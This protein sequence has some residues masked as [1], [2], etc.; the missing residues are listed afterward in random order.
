MPKKPYQPKSIEEHNF[1]SY[2]SSHKGV[3]FQAEPWPHPLNHE[4]TEDETIFSYEEYARKPHTP[5]PV[6]QISTQAANKLYPRVLD[7]PIRL[8]GDNTYHLPEE[9]AD[10]APILQGI[11]SHEHAHNPNWRDYHAYLTVDSSEVVKGDQ[12]RHG[13]LHVDGFQGDRINPKTKVNR[14]YVM[15]T[16]GGTRFYPQRF[17]I[18]DVTKYN[19][20]QGFDIQGGHYNIAEDHL[21]YLMDA[22]TVHES[23]TTARNGIRTFVRL[24]YDVKQ[25]DRAGNSHNSMLNYNWNMVTR[26]IHEGV[27]TPDFEKLET[28]PHLLPIPQDTYTGEPV[29]IGIHGKVGSGRNQ[30][31][32][33]ILK[34]LNYQQ[35]TAAKVSLLTSLYKEATSI[36]DD[37][38]TSQ[39]NHTITTR[40]NI[41]EPLLTRIRTLTEAGLG[42][43]DPEFGYYRGQDN[44]RQILDL[45]STYRRHNNPN[46]YIQEMVKTAPPVEFLVFSNLKYPNEAAWVRQNNG[47]LIKVE[48]RPRWQKATA[49]SEDGRK[50][51]E[52]RQTESETAL[53]K[54]TDW[55]IT[56]EEDSH[57][58]LR[59]VLLSRD[60]LHLAGRE[61]RHRDSY[62]A[63][64][65]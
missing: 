18:P 65:Q 16:N 37:I 27:K 29:I 7:M 3:T 12:Q 38:L 22:Y 2:I 55:D 19:I 42:P 24:S 21:I 50:Y 41:Q 47:F 61:I 33:E 14:S 39:D 52:G 46:Y 23:G 35:Y 28:S 57:Y 31:S 26:N 20:F 44:Y 34:E 15:T 43:R 8:A 49:T 4:A 54:W 40:H 17:I 48:P 9:W 10:L 25:F 53:D 62:T 63:Y 32:Y 5:H 1:D 64:V 6:P 56:I 36:C 51:A 60:L 58:A 30:F 45:I 59:P 13:G 11:I